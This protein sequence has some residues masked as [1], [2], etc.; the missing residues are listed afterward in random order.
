MT[1]ISWFPIFTRLSGQELAASLSCADPIIPKRR[2]GEKEK[3]RKQLIE[4]G[5]PE[6]AGRRNL[7]SWKGH[8]SIFLYT[9][10]C[11]LWDMT[12]QQNT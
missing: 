5:S 2:N 12:R 8:G 9:C 6:G 7:I 4:H 1:K 10:T 3:K 11:K